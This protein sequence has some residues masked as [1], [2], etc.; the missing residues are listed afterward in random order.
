MSMFSCSA[1]VSFAVI[2]TY[3]SDLF[4]SS[5]SPVTTA[6]TPAAAATQGTAL[7]A[8]L[9]SLDEAA[10]TSSALFKVLIVLTAPIIAV[11]KLVILLTTKTAIKVFPTSLSVSIICFEFLTIFPKKSTTFLTISPTF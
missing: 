10:A 11:T 6:A 4:A 7:M 8:A 5:T 9:K 2:S 1:S 3:S